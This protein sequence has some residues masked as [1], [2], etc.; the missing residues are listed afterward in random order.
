MHCSTP[1][2][3]K[4]FFK[5]NGHDCNCNDFNE[6][7]AQCSSDSN[8]Q[9]KQYIQQ[10]EKHVTV[11][12]DPQRA[13]LKHMLAAFTTGAALGESLG[14]Y[15]V[16]T[17][18]LHSLHSLFFTTTWISQNQKSKTSLDLNET[19]DD[20]VWGWQWHQLDH[21]QTICALLQTDNHTNT[22][23]LNCYRL[24]VLPDAKP[25]VSK[26]RRHTL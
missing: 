20:G 23:S 26:H 12:H 3:P 15:T 5:W 4:Q 18:T 16:T 10:I 21:M 22:S 7:F 14:A 19:R 13:G 9:S 17:T 2:T 8:T 6:S 25:T 11:P 24:D 1:K